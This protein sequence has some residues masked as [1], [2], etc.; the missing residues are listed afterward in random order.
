MGLFLW[1]HPLNT[2]ATFSIMFGITQLSAAIA[3]LTY[4]LYKKAKPIPWGKIL[5]SIGI[6]LS[7]FL[8]PF[9]SLTVILWIFVF[10]FLSMSIFYIQSLFRNRHQKWHM[11]QIALAILGIIYSF[12]MLLNPIAGFATMAKIL[13]FGVITNGLS[14][15]FS[16]NEN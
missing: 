7:M 2:L 13:A 5:V 3:L 1:N 12:I 4:S 6:G 10:S 8:I 14:Y 16:P 9:V 15:I 11:I